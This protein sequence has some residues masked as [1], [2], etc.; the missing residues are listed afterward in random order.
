MH[1]VLKVPYKYCCFSVRSAQ[2]R[3]QVGA[4]IGKGVP[5]FKKLF[6]DWKAKA[7][8]RMHSYDLDACEKC[9]HF[10]FNSKVKFSTR[11]DVFLDIIILPYFNTIS[12]CKVFNQLLL[13]VISTFVSGKCLYKRLNCCKIY[14]FI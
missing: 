8:N 3:I 1:E 5:F 9:C 11:F 13:C 10:W 6:S 12:T 4:K 7:T 14:V 2:G